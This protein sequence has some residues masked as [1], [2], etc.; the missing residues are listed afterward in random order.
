MAEVEGGKYIC[1]GRQIVGNSKRTDSATLSQEA[2][3]GVMVRSPQIQEIPGELDT[4]RGRETERSFH[5][6]APCLGCGRGRMENATGH[7]CWGHGPAPHM[8]PQD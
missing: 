6:P 7:R 8:T 3:K 1:W 4:C 5:F 2:K